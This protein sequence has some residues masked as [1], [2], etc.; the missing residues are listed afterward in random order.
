MRTSTD[1]MTSSLET[2]R[3]PETSTRQTTDGLT[4]KTNV[5][6]TTGGSTAF[7]GQSTV[8]RSTPFMETSASSLRSSIQMTTVRSTS[9]VETTEIKQTIGIEISMLSSKIAIHTTMISSTTNVTTNKTEV[10]KGT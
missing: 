4:S 8:V 5:P 2:V 10:P 1:R 3:Y 7:A 6:H 9:L